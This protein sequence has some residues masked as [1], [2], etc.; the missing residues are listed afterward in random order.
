VTEGTASVERVREELRQLGYLDAGIDRFALAGAGSASPLRA[1]AV[2]AARLGPA[3]GLLFGAAFTAAAALL[4]PD[5]LRDPRDFVVLLVY[6]SFAATLATSALALLAGLLAGWL[7]R[8]LERRPGPRLSRNVGLVLGAFGAAYLGLWWRSHA[9][10]APLGV[11]LALGAAALGLVLSLARFGSLAAVAVLSAGGTAERLPAARDARRHMAPLVAAAVLL[12]AVGAAAAARLGEVEDTGPDY[13]VRPTGLRVRVIGVDGLDAAL[14]LSMAARGEMPELAR[15]LPL[16][17]HARLQPEPEQVPAIVWTTVATGR[18]PEAHGVRGSGTRLA[19]MR[20]PV[21]FLSPEGGVSS[22]LA[23]A[24]DVLRI[25]RTEP[26]S[27]VLR[28]VKAFWNVASDKGLRVGIVNWWATWPAEPLNGY[29]VSDR[30]FLK[31]ERGAAPDR[32]VYPPDAFDVVKALLPPAADRARRRDLFHA[33][34]AARLRSG[35]PVD[36]EAVYLPG[37]DIFTNQQMLESPAD[38]G[39]L[40]ARLATIR[41]YY[42]FLDR[43]LGEM[44]EALGPDEMV[45]L[46]GDPGRF[47]RRTTSGL[48]MLW[49]GAARPGDLGTV[50]ERDVAPTVLHLVGLP[51]SRE[52]TGAVL[53]S[54][55]TAAF[56]DAHPVEHVARYARRRTAPAASGFDRE[57]IEELRSLGYIH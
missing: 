51:V 43:L 21:S 42:R 30:T 23:G 29:V 47:E 33:A 48:L 5:R 24:A 28:S 12:L 22:A 11:Q 14:A 7:G 3:G 4:E 18:G 16:S 55:L 2:V 32:E 8:R 38:L 6:I 53:T 20:A 10:E 36:L 50:S 40:D 35:H 9:V 1:C 25:T 44:T 31:V 46:V 56:N 45:V 19:G 17:A 52:L 37:L 26:P 49:G 27:A 57:M 13:A 41:E 39:A 15:R 54:G 34:A